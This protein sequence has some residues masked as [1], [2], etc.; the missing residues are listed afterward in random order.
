MAGITLI[1]VVFIVYL[2]LRLCDVERRRGFFRVFFPPNPSQVVPWGIGAIV[3]ALILFLSMTVLF[4][5]LILRIMPDPFPFLHDENERI[6]EQLEPAT[7]TVETPEPENDSGRGIITPFSDEEL[8]EQH[9]LTILM[10]K[11]G[12]YPIV[13]VVCFLVAVVVAPLTEELLFRVIMQGGIESTFRRRSG[14][15][16]RPCRLPIFLTAVFFAAIHIR[17]QPRADIDVRYI[18]ALFKA[19]IANILGSL[20]TLAVIVFLFR[21]V[22]RARWSDFGLRDFR[23][24]GR[25]VLGILLLLPVVFVPV[26]VVNGAVTLLAKTDWA[27]RSGISAAMLD[28]IPLFLFAL[29]LG[30]LY[31]RTRRLLPVFCLH[32]FF[33]LY[34]FLVLLSMAFSGR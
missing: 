2:A 13:I 10:Q 26:Y 25:D 16:T 14:D 7:S 9:P 11:G 19:M 1:S 33:N 5:V 29:I 22:Y 23:L 21:G 32:A 31:Y 6:A 12:R 28:P 15:T 20:V 34:S 30:S 3:P 18:D 4:Q 17:T 27:V 8:P 24:A